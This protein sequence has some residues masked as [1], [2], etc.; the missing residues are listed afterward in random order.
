[1]ADISQIDIP[2]AI[3]ALLTILVAVFGIVGKTYL[4][5]AMGGLALIADV[6]V[7]V[8]QLIITI[9]KA[10]EDGALS[11]EEWTKIK[12]QARDIQAHLLAIQGKLGTVL[13]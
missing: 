3:T 10:G 4:G 13:G 2:S 8:G 7:D 6:L 5:K 11:P 1:M 12:E 9:T